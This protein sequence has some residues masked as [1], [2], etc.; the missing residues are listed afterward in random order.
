MRS[1][2]RKRGSLGGPSER[3]EIRDIMGL[4]TLFLPFCYHQGEILQDLRSD[5]EERRKKAEQRADRKLAEDGDHTLFSRT[6]VNRSNDSG[7][8]GDNNK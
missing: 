1:V 5:D 7:S 8:P 2:S 6:V 4:K 3:R